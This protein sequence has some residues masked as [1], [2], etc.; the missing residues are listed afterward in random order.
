VA[1]GGEISYTSAVKGDGSTTRERRGAP[2]PGSVEFALS[3]SRF[4]TNE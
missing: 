1:H 4:N 2:V 3:G